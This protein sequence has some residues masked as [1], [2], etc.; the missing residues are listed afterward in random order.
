MKY[1]DIV[2][3]SGERYV[4]SSCGETRMVV[5]SIAVQRYPHRPEWACRWHRV[6][7]QVNKLAIRLLMSHLMTR[8]FYRELLIIEWLYSVTLDVR[9]MFVEFYL[10][11]YT[12]NTN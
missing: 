11:I 4:N 5:Y 8:I 2:R 12:V 3:L 10:C 9:K 6:D 7:V 1:L